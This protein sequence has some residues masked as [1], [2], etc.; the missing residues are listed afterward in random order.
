MILQTDTVKSEV[1]KFGDTVYLQH[2]SG[3]FLCGVHRGRYDWPQLGHMQKVKFQIDGNRSGE[4]RDGAII[5]L[6]STESMVGDRNTLGAFADSLDCYYWDDSYNPKKQG[7]QITKKGGSGDDTIRYGD[8]IYLTNLHH[9]HQRLSRCTRYKGFV[10]TVPR[11]NEWWCLKPE[12]TQDEGGISS[13]AA[14]LKQVF[15]P[16]T[17]KFSAANMAY[18]AYCAEAVYRSPQ[19]SKAKLQQLGFAI[20]GEAHF[21]EFTFSHTQ[22]IA[23]GDDEKIIIAFRGTEGLEDWKTNLKLDQAMWKVGLVHSGFYKSLTSVWPAAMKRLEALRTTNQPI[24]LT[25][26]SLGGALATLA[27]ATFQQEL[28]EYE[29]AGVYTFGQP[30]V[31]D[32]IF[33]QALDKE[34]QS[35]FFRVVNNNDI[36]T[37]IPKWKYAHAG[38][39]FYFDA[40]GNLLRDTIPS[41]RHRLEGY[42]KSLLNLD[43]DDIG[44]HRMGDYRLLT[45]RQ[46]G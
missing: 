43:P 35:R 29:I 38:R 39:L 7:W 4:I 18:L 45:M 28:P 37:R 34:H 22:C 10:T 2:M 16:E 17:R 42:Y 33:A 21:I 6:K 3:D 11:A 26:H 32:R 8:E 44:D 40:E 27:C 5:Q 15:D 25:G 23:V 46:L 30:K 1:L 24:W 19:E 14:L 36:V 12:G 41:L 31:G 13:E 20:E 9:S